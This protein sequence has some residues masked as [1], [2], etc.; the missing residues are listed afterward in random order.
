MTLHIMNWLDQSI[1][2]YKVQLQD[3]TVDFF[4]A[5]NRLNKHGTGVET[6]MDYFETC[7]R[8]AD[9]CKNNGDDTRYLEGLRKVYCRM[10]SELN[11]KQN[12]LSCRILSRKFAKETLNRTCD[13]YELYGIKE[14]TKILCTDFAQRS[15]LY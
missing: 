12:P 14:R 3:T 6:L 8:L 4:H 7:M 1:E 11:N 2:D 15:S 5:E 13:L 10:M 9:L